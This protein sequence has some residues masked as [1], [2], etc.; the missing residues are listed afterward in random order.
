MAAYGILKTE[1]T[2]ILIGA[3]IFFGATQERFAS[4]ANAALA[5]LRAGDICA[6]GALVLSPG[7]LLGSVLELM[8]RTPQPYFAVVHGERAI[9]T[10]SRDEAL[11]ALR[12]VGPAAYVAAVM[13]RDPLEVDASTPLDQLRSQLIELGGR[14]VL[15]R[16]ANG[17]LGLIGP[18]DISRT[19]TLMVFLERGRV[20][21]AESRS[22][23]SDA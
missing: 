20:R 17:Y 3:F 9:G 10:L 19:G 15:V 1:W 2:L 8:L 14:P 5:G 21:Q 22:G 7:D 6:P 11:N 16:G 13:Q 18:D 23:V 4:E 12:R